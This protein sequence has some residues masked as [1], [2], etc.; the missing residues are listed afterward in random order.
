MISRFT[1]RVWVNFDPDAAGANSAAKTLDLLV[2]DEFELRVITLEGGLDPDRFVREKGVTAYAAA[3]RTASPYADFWIERAKVVYPQQTP[4]AKVKRI[5]FVLPRIRMVSN[6]IARA[7]FADNAA[8]KLGIESSLMRQELKQA[9]AQR[10]E[11]VRAA[12][13]R[14]VTEVE[15]ILLCA[16]VLPDADSARALAVARLGENP[17]WFSGLG[18]A[19][20]MEVLVNGPAPE[21]PFEAAPDEGSRMLLASALQSASE[22]EMSAA[23]VEGALRS[24]KDL[25]LERR[26]RDLRIQIAETERRGDDAMKIRLMQELMHL[27]KEMKS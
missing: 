12:Q 10:L 21:N 5:N 27:N 7:E 26:I 20:V 16:L 23:K 14:A 2:Q 17:D 25:Y 18:S 15:K 11:S 1:K 22:E 9:A 8:Q 24:L 4:E 3:V 13:P 19:A 6:A